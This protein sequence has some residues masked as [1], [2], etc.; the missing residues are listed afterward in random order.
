MGLQG[1]AYGTV[2]ADNQ[3]ASLSSHGINITIDNA[4]VTDL[5]LVQK[6][7][8]SFS[9]NTNGHINIT[10]NGGTIPSLFGGND[11]SSIVMETLQSY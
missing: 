5:F 6:D 2:N 9:P 11:M 3:T 7:I 4:D 1:S 10:V 8:S